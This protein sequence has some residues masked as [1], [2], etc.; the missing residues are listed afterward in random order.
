MYLGIR[1]DQT[2]M[3]VSQEI[4]AFLFR[5]EIGESLPCFREETAHTVHEPVD[6]VFPAQEYAA[7]D[8]AEA[9]VRVRLSVGKSKAR[10]PGAAK[11][12]PTIDPEVPAEFFDILNQITGRVIGQLAKRCRTSGAP[13]VENDNAIGTWIEETAMGGNGACAWSAVQED[14]RHPPRVAALLPIKMMEA[15]DSKAARFKRLDFGK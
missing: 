10:P 13:L 8:K 2:P 12:K 9:A 3:V 1:I 5:K 11:H 7:Q 15:I 14:D 6:L 4:A